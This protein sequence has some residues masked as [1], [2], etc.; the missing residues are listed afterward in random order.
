[1]EEFKFI[2]KKILNNKILILSLVILITSVAFL[3][4]YLYLGVIN[5]D[6]NYNYMIKNSN[7]ST[8]YYLPN[9]EEEVP[10]IITD[11][12]VSI[13][14]YN[15]SLAALQDKYDINLSPYYEKQIK[16]L[17]T[18]YNFKYTNYQYKVI[19]QDGKAYFITTYNGEINKILS[20][21]DLNSLDNQILIT[22][23]KLLKD[24]NKVNLL[25]NSY[26][27]KGEFSSINNIQLFDLTNSTN[28]LT[29]NNIGLWMEK[30]QYNQINADEVEYYLLKFNNDKDLKEFNNTNINDATYYLDTNEYLTNF[31]DTINMNYQLA[32][33]ALIIYTFITLVILYITT[34]NLLD[35]LDKQFGLL[36]IVGIN[37]Q[38]IV[39][40]TQSIYLILSIIGL[41]I[42]NVLG[43]L[44]LDMMK[45]QFM[46]L[47]NFIYLKSTTYFINQ[48]IFSIFI[49]LIIFLIISTL[50]IKKLRLKTLVLIKSESLSKSSR[51]LRAS[52]NITNK[53]P[54]AGSL[55]SAFTLKKTSRLLIVII[56]V[57]LTGS[58]LAIG[59]G[60]YREQSSQ[61]ANLN[62]SVN[63]DNIYY[64]DDL[65]YQDNKNGA[66]INE[67]EIEL[68]NNNYNVTL[69][70]LHINGNVYPNDIYE[71]LGYN[72]IIVPKNFAIKNKIKQG[73]KIQLW[74][75]GKRKEL[76][77]SYILGSNYEARFFVNIDTLYDDLLAVY[78]INTY[79][80]NNEN[81]LIDQTILDKALRKDTL[82]TYIQSNNN[83]FAQIMMIVGV[84][85]LFSL[86]VVIL[87]FS[88]IASLNIHDSKED[89][90]IFK[91]LGY[92]R[93]D[94]FRYS[95][96]T[97]LLVIVTT[98]LVGYLTFPILCSTFENV[99]NVSNWQFYLG[100][101]NSITTY[102]IASLIIIINYYFW[103]FLVYIINTKVK[104]HK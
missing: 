65:Q 48:I 71:N 75:D 5:V 85:L 22:N 27:V 91:L 1:M 96:T 98:L 41:I 64:F 15:L 70:G 95:V 34:K 63:Y 35:S 16:K 104:K 78:A 28:N 69:V 42:G 38:R 37:K 67:A 3:F 54:F 97:Y 62:N 49:L 23:S 68:S 29:Q 7:P 26:D 6:D 21:V 13:E 73:D 53:I 32:Y 33:I 55:K 101:D 58:F 30:T 83:S 59:I 60:L 12:N 20:N 40:S 80:D 43:T 94:I 52:K 10:T 72:N 31:E 50:I 8:C 2:W 9:L 87:V 56:G 86:L 82:D 25:G 79:Y 17:Q 66:Y 90:K 77:V 44:N 36:K 19:S 51:I 103:M 47:Y 100:V 11:Y 57:F 93:F 39:L 81:N 46:P 18:K 99:L 45:N 84:L 89:I 102:L 61:V 14:D 24:K 74:L 88:L 76:T 92:K 4:N